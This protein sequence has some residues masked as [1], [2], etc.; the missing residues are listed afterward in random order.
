[1]SIQKRLKP[2]G[3]E[4]EA[5]LDYIRISILS[6]LFLREG[7]REG[8]KERERGRERRQRERGRGKDGEREEERNE[9][10]VLFSMATTGICGYLNSI[11]KIYG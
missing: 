6:L 9:Y 1:M 11:S 3:L 5:S 10:L 2:E 7:E 4:F 8:G